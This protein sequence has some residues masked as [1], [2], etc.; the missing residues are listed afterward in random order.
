MNNIAYYERKFSAL[1]E[2]YPDCTERINIL[3]KRYETQQDDEKLIDLFVLSVSYFMASRLSDALDHLIM[4]A[5]LAM[6]L[7]HAIFLVYAYNLIGAIYDYTGAFCYSLEAYLIAVE[8]GRHSKLYI[9]LEMVNNNLGELFLKVD[10]AELACHYYAKSCQHYLNEE[11]LT[12]FTKKRLIYMGNYIRGLVAV[13]NLE[14]AE[15]VLARIKYAT[16]KIDFPF[17]CNYEILYFDKIGA[18]TAMFDVF[19]KGV[20]R[21]QLPADKLLFIDL[22][23]DYGSILTRRNLPFDEALPWL[24]KAQAFAAEQGLYN[25]LIPLLKAIAEAYLKMGNINKALDYYDQYAELCDQNVPFKKNIMLTS[26]HYRLD[27]SLKD[28]ELMMIHEKDLMISQDE[29][30]LTKIA[31]CVGLIKKL[32]LQMTEMTDI[33]KIATTVFAYLKYLMQIDL[34]FIV[35]QDEAY[36]LSDVCL[37]VV[38]G[39]VIEME[40]VPFEEPESVA[41]QCFVECKTLYIAHTSKMLGTAG[42]VKGHRF[43]DVGWIESA[44][45]TPLIFNDKPIGVFSVQSYNIDQYD[46]SDIKII[47]ELA[48][49]LSIA[50]HSSI[51]NKKLMKATNSRNACQLE[52]TALKERLKHT[53]K[54]DQ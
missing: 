40:E 11:D 41:R 46:E 24:E 6:R 50:I 8:V 13:D 42:F 54:K 52:L 14:E 49:F 4:T 7:N 26:S 36:R 31:N 12:T 48:T 28:Y 25:K 47:S 43:K 21:Y 37:Y 2:Q 44:V 18:Q 20:T 33:K 19:R 1:Y 3:E 5:N 51:V 45:F 22:M 29:K 16:E 23:V 30:V 17:L 9:M 39:R 15:R 32:G 27:L 10:N 35:I 53:N 34:F 38:E